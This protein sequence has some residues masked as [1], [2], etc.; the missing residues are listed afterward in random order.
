MAQREKS[1]RLHSCSACGYN[2]PKWFGK[3]PECG[4]WSSAVESSG[5]QPGDGLRVTSLAECGPAPARMPS[6]LDEV[7]RVLGGGLVMGE[8]VLLGG[9][10]GAGKSTLVLQLLDGLLAQG[11]TGLLVSGEES[12]HQI[13]LRAARLRVDVS[14]LRLA[15]GE[16]LQATLA[17]CAREQPDVLVVD[18]VQTLVDTSLEQ[19]A[20]S[21]VQVR[22]CAA[23]LV[24]YAKT[25]GTAVILVGHVTKDGAIAGP[26]TLEH[27]VDAVLA[28]DG[29]RDG[30]LRLL[31][32]SKNR[33]GSCDEIGVL[34]MSAGG[35]Q[36][37]EDPSALLLAD[38]RAGIEGS[39][40]F[41]SVEG[42]RPILVELQALA[43]E[44]RAPQPRRV[45]LGI[46]PRRL[47]LVCAVL[48]DKTD[49]SFFD[50]DV[51]VSAAGG[52]VIKE[53][54]AD[55]AL[56]MALASTVMASPLDPAVIA[57]GEVGLGGEVRRV[58]AL[59]RRIDEAMR[60]GFKRI[61]VPPETDV[62]RPGLDIEVVANV[63]DA[64]AIVRRPQT[65]S[66]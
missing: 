52:L 54:A 1:R 3:C 60:M 33:F 45:A 50:R 28:L 46:E 62:D 11:R 12:A 4:A 19:A 23:A 48:S 6:G 25:S 32:A 15:V 39:I 43:P 8:V 49:L 57:I 51:F 37:V 20:G 40:V 29:E 18:S 64:V 26:K 35:L 17:T 53:P 44:T 5:S 34:S 13:A 38:R 21:V 24:R 47:A 58:R 56:A 55:L 10:P 7:D 41:P 16:S 36:R 42:I 14:R 9:E 22:E 65:A 66:R 30:T 59:D 31:R 27:V 2:T 63:R 61:V